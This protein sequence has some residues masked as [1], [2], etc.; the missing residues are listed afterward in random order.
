M[1]RKHLLMRIVTYTLLLIGAGVFAMPLIWMVLTA[2]KPVDQAMANPPTFVPLRW[3]TELD[4]QRLQ[5]GVIDLPEAPADDTP[6]P[7]QMVSQWRLDVAGESVPVA[8][9]TGS[10]PLPGV[11]AVDEV[12]VKLSYHRRATLDAAAIDAMAINDRNKELARGWLMG[13]DLPVRVVEAD[14]VDPPP[15]GWVLAA[16]YK[17]DGTFLWRVP[18]PEPLLRKVYNTDADRVGASYS[19]TELRTVARS[20]LLQVFHPWDEH[21]RIPFEELESVTLPFSALDSTVAPR[22]ENFGRSIDE[23]EMFNTYLFNTLFLCLLTVVGTVISS[24]MVAYGFSRLDWPGRDKLFGVVLAT[25]MIPFPVLMVPMYALF[26]EM[27]WIGSL[28]PL[29]VPFFFA[30][31]FNVFLLRQFFMT[32]PRDITE[33]ARIDGCSELRIFLQ[34]ILPLAKPALMVVALFQFMAT[35]NDFL[36]P[37]IYLADQED[38]TLALGLLRFQSQHGGTPWHLIMA[39]STL[40]VMPV[41]VLFFVTQRTFIEGISMTGSKG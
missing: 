18:V 25:M 20:E 7:V 3:Y 13:R 10:D 5:V 29:W 28:K 12:E 30:G 8:L 9:V 16:F 11:P 36:G 19:E 33:A 34:I 4:G 32:I 37:Q 23:M 35:W 27:G 17:D 24:A 6:V 38:F 1:Q 39:A 41:I 15:A 26:R 22:F 14:S 21:E 31:A 2:L 40:V